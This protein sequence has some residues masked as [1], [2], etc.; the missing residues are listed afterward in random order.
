[1]R[2]LRNIALILFAVLAFASTGEVAVRADM[3]ETC[4]DVREISECTQC[5]PEPRSVGVCY[6]FSNN[7]DSYD[8]CSG[9]TGPSPICE[10]GGP[11]EP[12]CGDDIWF[13][14]CEP[15]EGT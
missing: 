12:Q 1:M 11:N 8:E 9:G 15:C 10:W 2:V 6:S 13:C 7:C 14:E 4:S 3:C 5:G